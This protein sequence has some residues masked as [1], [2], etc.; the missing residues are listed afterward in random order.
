MAGLIK[1]ALVLRHGVIPPSL[2][3]DTPNPR[4][5]LER[6]PFTVNTRARP[7]EWAVG[8]RRVGVNSVGM[9][10]TNAFVVLEEAPPRAPTPPR[11]RPVS[12]LTMSAGTEAALLDQV[13]K[14]RDA[15]ASD[16][17]LALPDVCF[18][19]NRGRHHFAR[20]F[21][22]IGRDRDEMLAE[23]ERFLQTPRPPGGAVEAGSRGPV[24]FLFS[25][26]GSQYARMG[27]ATYRAEARFRDAM[28]RCFSLFLAAG[29][30]VAET[31]FADDEPRLHRTQ[32]AQPALFSL[33][34]AL[35]ELWRSWG[36]T[37]DVVIGHSVGEFAAAVTAGVCSLEDAVRLVSTRARLME[38]L[39]PDGGMVSIGSDLETVL[40][41]WPD[42]RE[43]LTLAAINA[44]D[45]VVASGSV[46]ADGSDT[47]S[48]TPIFR[49]CLTA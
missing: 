31:L 35:V 16:D 32:Y 26:Q 7:F 21:A 3:F 38:D 29:I 33:Q 19:A 39:A 5:L 11:A 40:A 27:E 48:R 1:A 37:P 42:G 8:P 4:I 28:D 45:R 12:I 41:A 49:R 20:R 18:S 24:V 6:S 47:G 9:G 17:S 13:G 34:V 30:Q 2:H 23:L 25:G 10:G 14:V 46:T 36:V 22:G 15:L 43:D 44:P